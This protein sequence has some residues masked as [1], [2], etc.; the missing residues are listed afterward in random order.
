M[1]SLGYERPGKLRRSSIGL[2]ALVGPELTNPIF[3]AFAQ[4]VETHLAAAS[5]S[6]VLCTPVLGGIYEGDYVP[7]LLERGVAGMHREYLFAPELILRRSTGA[8]PGRR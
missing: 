6:P 8:A 5:Y 2:V 4:A 3:P 7:M 1:S